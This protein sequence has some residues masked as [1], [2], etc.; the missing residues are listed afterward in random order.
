MQ[1][2]QV[3]LETKLEDCTTLNQAIWGRTGNTESEIEEEM[4]LAEEFH[5]KILTQ[6]N[7]IK[8]F[9]S[10]FETSQAE[11]SHSTAASP[12]THS[13]SLKMPKFNLPTFDGSYEKWTP[14]Y[15]PFMASVEVIRVLLTFINSIN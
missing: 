4:I 14:F 6:I 12:L 7:K 5:L 3:T 10:Y 1:A 15:E 2:R 11:T 13:N 9:L 8:R